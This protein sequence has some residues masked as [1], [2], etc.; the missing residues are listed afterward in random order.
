MISTQLSLFL[1]QPKN[2]QIHHHLKGRAMR[3]KATPSTRSKHGLD[4]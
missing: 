4:V 3:G 1:E 2:H